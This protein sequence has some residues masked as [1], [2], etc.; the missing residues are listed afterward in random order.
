MVQAFML[1]IRVRFCASFVKLTDVLDLCSN[2]H[3]CVLR[4]V[5]LTKMALHQG[6]LQPGMPMMGAPQ[7]LIGLYDHSLCLSLYMCKF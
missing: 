2:L 1:P 7:G 6:L 5:Q 3:A 4:C